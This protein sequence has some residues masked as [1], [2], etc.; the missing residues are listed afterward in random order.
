MTQSVDVPTRSAVINGA[1]AGNQVRSDLAARALASDA[2]T[3]QENIGMLTAAAAAIAKHEEQSDGGFRSPTSFTSPSSTGRRGTFGNSIP[4]DSIDGKL[5]GTSANNAKYG[6]G[7]A[8]ALK[9]W[10]SM[11]FVRAGWF[12]ADEA[13]NYIEFFYV[14]LAPMTP[15]SPPDFRHPSKHLALLTDEPVLAIAM[16]MIASRHMRLS[17]HAAMT[18]AARIHDTLWDYL[19]CMVERL[20]WGQEQFGGGFCAAGTVKVRESQGGQLTW[21]GSLRTLGTV[22]ALL[23]LTDWQPRALHFPPGDDE[24]RLLDTNYNLLSDNNDSA[25]DDHEEADARQGRPYGAWLEPT[26]RSDRMSWMLLGLAQALSFELG[27]FDNNHYD[28]INDHDSASSCA[29][30]R[31][32]RRMVLVYVSQTSGRLGLPSMLPL[33]QWSKDKVFEETSRQQSHGQPEGTVD[34]MQSCWLD[35]ARVMYDAN[36]ILFPTRKF[37]R[38]LTATD[39]YKAKIAIFKPMLKEWKDNFESVKSTFHP[40]MQ[41][42][43]N[44]EYEYARCYINSLGLQKVVESWV[45][46]PAGE[47]NGTNAAHSDHQLKLRDLYSPNHEYIEAVADSARM[48]LR[49]VVDGLAPS[50]SL[51]NAPVRTFLRSISGMMFTLKRFGVGAF[52]GDVRQALELLDLSTDLMERDVVDDVHLSSQIGGLIKLLVANIRKTF[53]RV[54]GKENG[55]ETASRQDTPQHA[56]SQPHQVHPSDASAQQPARK[57]ARLSANPRHQHSRDPLEGIQAQPLEDLSNHTFM[58][59]PNIYPFNGLDANLQIDSNTDPS[60]LDPI[61]MDWLTLP[62]DNLFNSS[63][64]IV[65]Q[66]FGGIGPTVG[67]RDML[68]L[69]TNEHYDQWNMPNNMPNMNFGNGYHQ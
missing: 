1:K 8:L 29:R 21:K 16:L 7:Y 13:M 25:V 27:V 43:L 12:T 17:G 33:P 40:L 66:G 38:S 23:L 61:T 24:N 36:K 62:L 31:R 15:I 55:S 67:D 51:R 18:R 34:I 39:E 4:S 59:P 11:R 63:T 46:M 65:D 58:P 52:E 32:V 6:E 26:W 69:I 45:S 2:P 68:E 47:S 3:T 41:H 44:M 60:M 9:A 50:G 64:G 49:G 54:Q 35:I 56:T 28:C 53:I 20:L 37:T 57:R 48:I 19:R 22:E 10:A 30:K 5:N 14:H 42:V